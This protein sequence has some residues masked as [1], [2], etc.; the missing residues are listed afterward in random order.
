[1]LTQKEFLDTTKPHYE[2][3]PNDR[4]HPAGYVVIRV[5]GGDS[6]TPLEDRRYLPVRAGYGQGARCR[7]ART[8]DRCAP[9]TRAELDALEAA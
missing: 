3:N 2:R 8:K 4:K 9:V 5:D 1:M 7:R 6:S